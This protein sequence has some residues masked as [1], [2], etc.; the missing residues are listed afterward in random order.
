M[1]SAI[2]SAKKTC[3]DGTTQECAAAWDEV[4]P[5]STA[6]LAYLA[7]LPHTYA[8][9]AASCGGWKVHTYVQ[10][11]NMSGLPRS[12]DEDWKSKANVSCSVICTST[13]MTVLVA[14]G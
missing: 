8:S 9:F 5:S 3:D 12:G 1:E 13:P 4:G 2:E 7:V 14:S 10:I 6:G 11:G